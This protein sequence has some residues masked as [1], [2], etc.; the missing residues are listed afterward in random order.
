MPI[1]DN[2]LA[3]P[4]ND[5]AG[6]NRHQRPEIATGAVRDAVNQFAPADR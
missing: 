3:L 5:A 2:A 6:A 4:D 1:Q